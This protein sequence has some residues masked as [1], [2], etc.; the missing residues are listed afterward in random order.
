MRR[1]RTFRRVIVAGFVRLS[2]TFLII[3]LCCKQG[4]ILTI[5]L[6]YN[7]SRV[8]IALQAAHKPCGVLV[9]KENRT[10][11]RYIQLSRIT[12]MN[13]LRSVS[14]NNCESQHWKFNHVEQYDRAGPLFFKI[15]LFFH[16]AA[17]HR[18]DVVIE[19]FKW[20]LPSHR[21]AKRE[22]V[23]RQYSKPCTAIITTIT[24]VSGSRLVADST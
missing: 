9:T 22:Q 17:S 19:G 6:A 10:N 8:S 21:G 23:E 24:S 14:N 12:V 4:R 18:Q 2:N 15:S 3:L 20:F 16:V 5:F 1:T 13:Q 11:L 7:D